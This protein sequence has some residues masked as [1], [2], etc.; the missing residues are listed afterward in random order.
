MA[1]KRT[2]KAKS[3]KPAS[4]KGQEKPGLR[5]AP[6]QD[7][8]GPFPPQGDGFLGGACA[9]L[10]LLVGE[11]QHMIC[12]EID[13]RYVDLKG[14]RKNKFAALRAPL[15]LK[16]AKLYGYVQET[17]D[18]GERLLAEMQDMVTED[19]LVIEQRIKV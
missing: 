12:M 4:D 11:L 5:K 8:K 7:G 15:R 13:S 14:N 17:Y 3:G 10:Y 16:L 9:D 1:R 2:R 18:H 6:R 19:G